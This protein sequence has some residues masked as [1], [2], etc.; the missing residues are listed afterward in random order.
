MITLTPIDTCPRQEIKESNH[1]GLILSKTDPP[2]GG[3]FSKTCVFSKT[4]CFENLLQNDLDYIIQHWN[5]HYIRKSRYEGVS[6]C[7]DSISF[8]PENYGGNDHKINVT[9]KDFNYA[10]NDIVHHEESNEYTEYFDYVRATANIAMPTNWRQA[11]TVF[12]RLLLISKEG[13]E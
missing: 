12:D 10:Q 1:G 9:D 2:D 4:H 13:E 6:G 11:L 5:T 3:T 8:L 7:P